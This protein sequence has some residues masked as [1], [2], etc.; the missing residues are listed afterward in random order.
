[1][2][3]VLDEIIPELLRRGVSEQDIQTM[4]CDNARRWFEGL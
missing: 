4:M 3:F 2:T 1:M